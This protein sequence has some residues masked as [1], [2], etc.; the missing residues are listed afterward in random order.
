MFLECENVSHVLWECSAYSKT[1]ASFMKKLQEFLDDDYEDFESLENVE[2]SSYV[3]G[4]ELWESKFDGLLALVK[5][6][7]VDVWEIRKHNSDS[8]SGLQL[9]A[10]SSPGERK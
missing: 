2:K 8:G 6:Y 3:L 10:R 4:S 1:R 9:H 5:E 7:V